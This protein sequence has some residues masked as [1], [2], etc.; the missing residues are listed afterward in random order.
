MSKYIYMAFAAI[1]FLFVP[2]TAWSQTC[3]ESTSCTTSPAPYCDG[4]VAVRYAP[5]GTCE[6][7]GS[8]GSGEC[9]YDITRTSC[10][11][12]TRCYAG[13]CVPTTRPAVPASPTQCADIEPTQS[14]CSGN[15]GTLYWVSTGTSGACVIQSETFVCSEATSCVINGQQSYCEAVGP[16]IVVDA[17]PANVGTED[18]LSWT[19]WAQ[20]VSYSAQDAWHASNGT[21]YE[22]EGRRAVTCGNLVEFMNV[23][24]ND[25][26]T[27]VARRRLAMGR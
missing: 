3:T 1:L 12:A 2:V 4:S 26:K 9:E 16:T 19:Q 8:G 23:A 24:T 27:A 25:E 11:G 15:G 7:E 18:G 10:T 22:L 17:R 21:C 13:E 5:T 14:T 6:M 20:F